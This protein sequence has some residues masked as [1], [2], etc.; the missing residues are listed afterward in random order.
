MRKLF[1][2]RENV[3]SREA[4]PG[5][6]SRSY[7]QMGICAESRVE[8]LAR[9]VHVEKVLAGMPP[10]SHSPDTYGDTTACHHPGAVV[11]MWKERC[12]RRARVYRAAANRALE[13]QIV[14]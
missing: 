2:A 4:Q 14:W 10:V 7:T 9:A 13:T 5:G 11:V 12:V 6:I 1:P 3:C 8:I